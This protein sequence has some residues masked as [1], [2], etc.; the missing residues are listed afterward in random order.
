M[1]KYGCDHIIFS[2]SATVYGV[3]HSPITEDTPIGS[4]ITNA[5]GRTKFMIEE[6][7]KD[8]IASKVLLTKQ[9]T[10]KKQGQDHQQ[11][12]QVEDIRVFTAVILRY[13]NPVG[14]HS[15]GLIGE[16]PGGIPN[17]LM[18]YV[19]QVAV[20][21]REKLTVFGNDYNTVDGT[22]VRDFIHVMDLAEGHL[23]AL[24]S[25]VHGVSTNKSILEGSVQEESK[26]RV[27][28]LG[29]GQGTSVL[30]MI[31][32]METACGHSIN[33]VFG[34][35]RA[36]DIDTCYADVNKAKVELNWTC[37]RNLNDM[38]QG[39]VAF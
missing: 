37:K 12:E 14:A 29:T 3:A 32:A 17:N 21:R 22:G 9:Q 28:N 25:V 39:I 13:F 23:A 15:S 7:I 4:G 30:Q 36:G 2:S 33:Y 35:R 20:G 16:D 10:L 38:C 27:Y 26:V 19:A 11:Q 6:I 1:D 18:P 24:E 34:S 8:Y 31:A 5:Y